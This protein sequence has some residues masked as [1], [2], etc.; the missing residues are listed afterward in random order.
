M[1]TASGDEEPEEIEVT[2]G[3]GYT[4]SG[5]QDKGDPDITV[6]TITDDESR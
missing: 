2:T 4:Y 3:S 6:I 1:D 5:L